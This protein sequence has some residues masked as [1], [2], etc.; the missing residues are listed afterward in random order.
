VRGPATEVDLPLVPAEP[1]GLRF[2]DLDGVL[3]EVK[4]ES[5]K[6]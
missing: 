2:N 6:N 4:M 5:W 1:K 3:A